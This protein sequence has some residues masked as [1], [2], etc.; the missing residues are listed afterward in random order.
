MHEFAVLDVSGPNRPSAR[1]R[2]RG[3]DIQARVW[4]GQ[5]TCS[6]SHSEGSDPDPRGL[7][8]VISQDPRSLLRFVLCGC[9][10][11][12]RVHGLLAR[13]QLLVRLLISGGQDT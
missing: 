8:L 7:T 10:L 13:T 12:F 11:D 4:I 1:I 3:E 5:V 2:Y 6:G 9:F